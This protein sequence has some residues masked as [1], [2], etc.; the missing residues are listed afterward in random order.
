MRL[1]DPVLRLL[2]LQHQRLTPLPRLRLLALIG[3]AI[4]FAVRGKPLA[5]AHF[6]VLFATVALWLVPAL[7]LVREGPQRRRAI[8]AM[9][10]VPRRA[11]AAVLLALPPVIAI[12]IV[13]AATML[14]G[15]R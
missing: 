4:A 15:G 13:L 10:V 14:G 6:G 12:A 1:R 11:L 2:L 8:A 9:P 3:L 7:A 5:V